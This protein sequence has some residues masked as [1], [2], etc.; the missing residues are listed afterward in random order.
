MGAATGAGGTVEFWEAV[1]GSGGA[2]DS[3]AASAGTGFWQ[4]VPWQMLLLVEEAIT[5]CVEGCEGKMSLEKTRGASGWERSQKAATRLANP[6]INHN[7]E[8]PEFCLT[9]SRFMNALLLNT[10]LPPA[11]LYTAMR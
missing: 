1:A 2:E 10:I 6:P 7:I 8:N 9:P 11:R 5:P 3:T 4:F